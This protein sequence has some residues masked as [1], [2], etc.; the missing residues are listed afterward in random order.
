MLLRRPHAQRR[1]FVSYPRIGS[2]SRFCRD[3]LIDSEAE[4][5]VLVEM[6]AEHARD[7]IR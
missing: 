3:L 5:R 1:A 4:S 7:V 2:I 6:R